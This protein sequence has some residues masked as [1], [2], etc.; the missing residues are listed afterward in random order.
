MKIWHKRIREDPVNMGYLWNK[1]SLVLTIE[2]FF[3][4][5]SSLTLWFVA[6]FFLC[7][8]FPFPLSL[9][10][11]FFL[12]CACL[13]PGLLVLLLLLVPCDCVRL[14]EFCIVWDLG[15]YCECEDLWNSSLGHF[16]QRSVPLFSP[17]LRRILFSPLF[18]PIKRCPIWN[19]VAHSALITSSPLLDLP[20]FLGQD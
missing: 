15:S 17:C 3:G 18:F 19:D 14:R 7:P 8:I 5:F 1:M 2:S 13:C 6:L 10:T 11:F 16:V 4:F 20:S 12:F 9:S